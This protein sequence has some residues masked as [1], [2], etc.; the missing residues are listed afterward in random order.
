M[1]DL[2]TKGSP[3]LQ[4]INEMEV[5]SKENY[6]VHS[7]LQQLES[8]I[9]KLRTELFKLNPDL[10][11]ESSGRDMFINNNNSLRDE[12][13]GIDDHT[14]ARTTAS[15]KKFSLEELAPK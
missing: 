10:N 1:E 9:T 15:M 8:V 14:E 12:A 3:V 11:Q 5:E 2:A 13:L 7:L 6:L 4:I